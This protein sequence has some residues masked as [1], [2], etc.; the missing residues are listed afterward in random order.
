MYSSREVAKLVSVAIEDDLGVAQ[1][2]KAHGHFA[3]LAFGQSDH[4]VGGLVELMCRHGEGVLQSM[5]HHESAGFVDV[6]LLHDEFDDRVRGH[7]IESAGR[8]VVEQH[9]GLGDDGASD[10]HAPPHATREFGRTHVVGSFQLHEAQHLA[11]PPLDF[12]RGDALFHQAESDVFVNFERVEE[13]AF[14]EHDADA[15]AQFEQFLFRH[16]R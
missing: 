16:A 11:H 1:N 3:M 13:R 4:L 10:G 15:P 2:Q 6:A 7:R 8:R 12:F 5:G 14:L 9:L